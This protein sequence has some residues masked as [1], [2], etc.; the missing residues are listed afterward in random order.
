MCFRLVNDGYLVNCVMYYVQT[1][2]A[3]VVEGLIA[4]AT[5]YFNWHQVSASTKPITLSLLVR[6]LLLLRYYYYY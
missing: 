5:R 1:G 6:V 3:S 4:E 2:N